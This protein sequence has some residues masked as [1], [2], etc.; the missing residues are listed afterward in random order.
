MHGKQALKVNW[1][2]CIKKYLFTAIS[3]VHP[4]T[5][6]PGFYQNHINLHSE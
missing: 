3:A 5:S 2:L 6:G 4:L 1:E